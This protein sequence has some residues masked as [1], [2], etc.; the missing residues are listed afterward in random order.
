MSEFQKSKKREKRLQRN[1]TRAGIVA[2]ADVLPVIANPEISAVEFHGHKVNVTSLRLRNF[3][4]SQT[5]SK[6]GLVA[7]HFAVETNSGND[8]HLNLWADRG[9]DKAEMLF[10]HDHTL[11]RGLG[12][13]DS[14]ENTTTMCAKCN[15]AKS[16]EEL[17]AYNKLHGLPPPG[18]GKAKRRK[19]ARERI[20]N[21]K[22]VEVGTPVVKT[23]GRKFK[24]DQ[25]VATVTAMCSSLLDPKRRLAYVLEDESM[26]ACNHVVAA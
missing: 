21:P 2:I 5:C 11:A 13:D 19:A 4:K 9:P 1:Y 8:W 10:T 7:T 23:S 17:V 18:S 12:G 14:E 15:F 26:I 20:E 3:V 6:C 24:N 25:Y 16:R 22:L